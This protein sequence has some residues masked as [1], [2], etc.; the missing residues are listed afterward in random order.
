[1]RLLV[2]ALI[3]NLVL[4]TSSYGQT[5]TEW[6]E[7]YKLTVLDF[8]AEAPTSR[9]DQGQSYFLA[10]NLDFAY[11]MSSYEFMLTKN[12]NKF[13]KAYFNPDLSWLQQGEGTEVLLK[14][15]QMDF[16]LLELHARKYR[17]RIYTEK[18]ALSNPNFFKQ[19]HDEINAEMAR[20]QVDMQNAIA[21]SEGKR[22]AFHEQLL[23]EIGELAE[24]CK[25]C[26]PAKKKK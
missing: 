8:R 2:L 6:R 14:Y 3:I 5:K 12:F 26:K 21:E 7:N 18:K 20:R 17:Q 10:G 19:T 1:M 23:K 22:D 4:F 24:F 13:V 11:A 16:D 9:E 25:E 15:A